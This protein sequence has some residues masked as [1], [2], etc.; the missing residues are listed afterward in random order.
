MDSPET[1][2]VT[3]GAGYLGSVLVPH[4][5]GEG[6]RVRV[7]DNF[8]HR[9]PSLLAHCL[10][11][12]LE[13]TKAD[14]RDERAVQE[15][16]RGVRWIIP[17]AAIVGAP[18]CDA[19]PTA[20]VSTNLDAIRLLTALRGR[21]QRILFPVT[22]SG[23]GI[24]QKDVYCTEESPLRPISL[25]GRTKVEAEKVVLD[26]GAS[27]TFRLATA[28][29]AAPRMRLDLLV[30]DFTYRAVTDRV[31]VLFEA[32]FKRNYI[33]VRDIARVFVHGMKN[34]EAMQGRPYNVGLSDANLS[35]YELCEVI[36][37]V[38][39][40]FQFFKA[41]IGEDPDKRDYIVSN[42]RLES[43]G[44]RPQVGLKQGVH[45]LVKAYRMLP[46]SPFTNL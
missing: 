8:R 35:K 37:S 26:A 20:A 28:F 33:H 9:Q 10:D 21:E 14:G 29:G 4:L 5:L 42:E 2:L 40:A 24:G 41:D 45:E 23:Y 19:D 31:V 22:N 43:T 18:A 38:V 17:L 25:Y 3:G 39:P 7:L 27:V 12:R 34:F 11:D 13:L 1:V 15:A 36:K 32:H 46:A 6:Y 44:F 30:N 16:L